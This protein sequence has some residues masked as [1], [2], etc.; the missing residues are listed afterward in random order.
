LCQTNLVWTAG[1]EAPLQI[2]AVGADAKPWP[3]PVAAHLQ[4]QR[5]E[6][7]PVRVQGAGRTIRYRTQTVYS[8]VLERD[9]EIHGPTTQHLAVTEAGQY[10]LQFSPRTLM[11][12]RRPVALE[13]TV[14]AP[15][16]AVTTP[17]GLA[18][19]YRDEVRMELQP[20]QT[21]YAPG[22]TARL[23]VKA[24]FSGMA[25]VTVERDSVLRSF[26]TRLEGNAPVIEIPI[27]R[28]YPPNVFVS[29]LLT[30]GS[31]GCRG[32]QEPEYRVGYCLLPVHDPAGRLPC[33]SFARPPII[34]PP[35]RWRSR[36]MSTIFQTRPWPARK[37]RSTRWTRA[38]SA[39][40]TRAARIRARFL[41]AA[42]VGGQFRHVPAEPAA[43]RP[44]TAPV[45][46]QRIHGRRRRADPCAQ[47]FPRLRVLER[48]SGHRPAR[49][50]HRQ[51]PRT[52]QFDALPHHG[53]RAPGRSFRL[54]A[55]G[56]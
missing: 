21:E 31:D 2:V 51:V 12:A 15:E 52:R 41:C 11:A 46:Q 38:S 22:E 35:K 42:S 28:N 43:G 9:I 1:R 10:V 36:S 19:D 23:L 53:G 7:L 17:G 25:W 8:N 54:R 20:D 39:W 44:R 29:V 50:S 55:I 18:W 56:L 4:L 45:W 30:R 47:E 37:S 34:S 33:P 27:E 3:Q 6:S 26:S 49:H 48:D 40:A 24:P 14:C 16:P 32:C 13:F 5:V